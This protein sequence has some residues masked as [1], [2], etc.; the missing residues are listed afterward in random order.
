MNQWGSYNYNMY[1]YIC[2]ISFE[3]KIMIMKNN[4]NQTFQMN[5][6]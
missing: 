1:M 2:D 5:A 3:N 4:F 6:Y